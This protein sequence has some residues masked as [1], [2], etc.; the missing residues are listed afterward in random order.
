MLYCN[1]NYSTVLILKKI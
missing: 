1:A